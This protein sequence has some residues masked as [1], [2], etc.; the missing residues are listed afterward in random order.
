MTNH[1]QALRLL[2]TLHKYAARGKIVTMTRLSIDTG[3]PTTT[4]KS[5]LIWL[6]RAGLAEADWPR[7]TLSGL[8]IAVA[9]GAR[10]KS[11]SYSRAA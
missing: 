6:D 11:R 2:T 4:V 5:L 9:A 8:A 7:L 1:P 3:L 10:H